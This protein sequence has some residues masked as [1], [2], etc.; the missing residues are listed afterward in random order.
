[1]AAVPAHFRPFQSSLLA[2]LGWLALL[3]YLAWAMS[4][5]EFNWTRF[6]N[7]LDHGAK[8]IHRMFPPNFE[9]W[10]LLVCPIAATT[11]MRHDQQGMRWERMIP[12]NGRAQPQTT[13]LFWAGYPGAVGLPATA[14]PLELAA[15]G[16]P[17]GAQ[18]V[19][20]AFGD[21][22]CLR[23]ARWLETAYR[24]FVAPPLAAAG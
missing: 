12:V 15:D 19:G 9:R 5:L 7:G 22:M 17:V 2:R 21:P 11:A 8:F 13:Q 18:V 23:F 3:L 10:D 4:S 24:G 16:L 1:M 14:V 20:P 6:V